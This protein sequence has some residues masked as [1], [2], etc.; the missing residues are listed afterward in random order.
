MGGCVFLVGVLL[1]RFE[2]FWPLAAK[3]LPELPQNLHEILLVD[4]LALGDPVEADDTHAFKERNHHELPNG[5]ALSGL[6]ESGGV[7]VLPLGT[8]SSGLWIVT[9]SLHGSKK[10][11]PYAVFIM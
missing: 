11:S 10:V 4:H 3:S 1:A 2:E 9:T 7:G 5:S 8:L 6:L